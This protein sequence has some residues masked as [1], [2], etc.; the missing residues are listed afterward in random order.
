MRHTRSYWTGRPAAY[1]VLHRIGFFVPPSLQTTRWALTPP[2]HYDRTGVGEPSLP[3]YLFSVTLSVAAASPAAPRLER[4]I[5]VAIKDCSANPS[6]LSTGILPDG[7]RTF[8]SKFNRHGVTR[9]LGSKN[10]ERRSDSET[11]AGRFSALARGS[12]AALWPRDFRRMRPAAPQR[13]RARA[14]SR[15]H[16]EAA[17]AGHVLTCALE[18]SA[19]PPDDAAALVAL[20]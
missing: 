16:F 18:S 13:C 17:C 11:K 12:K 15:G 1:F 9:T 14:P 20:G 19:F 6:R 5:R 7:V 2:F 8:L 4:S 10:S 3:G